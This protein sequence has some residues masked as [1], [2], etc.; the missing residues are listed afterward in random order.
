MRGLFRIAAVRALLMQL[1]ARGAHPRPFGR[2]L[3]H[4]RGNFPKEVPVWKQTGFLAKHFSRQ[5]K[6][7]SRVLD[8]TFKNRWVLIGV[9]L[10][11]CNSLELI[12]KQLLFYSYNQA[13]L[14]KSGCRNCAVVCFSKCNCSIDLLYICVY[15]Y[16]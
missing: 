8:F 10:L 1:P 5:K 2:G 6:G 14:Q 16:V 11:H 13:D 3:G 15:K 12:A 4:G 7:G 9:F